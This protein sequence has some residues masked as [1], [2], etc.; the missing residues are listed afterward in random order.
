M[1]DFLLMVAIGIPATAVA[2][3]ALF[4]VFNRGRL[5]VLQGR[6]GDLLVG[7]LLVLLAG[8]LAL[9]LG[10]S[11]QEPAVSTLG[12]LVIGGGFAMAFAAAII[13]IRAAEVEQT[14]QASALKGAAASRS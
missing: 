5:P 9:L 13:L 3:F 2:A 14:E 7:A 1:A 11:G 12:W 6:G 4:L 8:H 10:V